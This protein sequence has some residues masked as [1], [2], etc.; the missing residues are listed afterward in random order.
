MFYN[1]VFTVLGQYIQQPITISTGPSFPWKILP[2][3]A[4]QL[5]KFRGSPR[6]NRPNSAAGHGRLF[7]TETEKTVQKLQLL[8]A[9]TVL[10]DDTH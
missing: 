1:L 10:K 5:A 9:D 6:Q 4:G 2:N 7:M 8:K 3:S